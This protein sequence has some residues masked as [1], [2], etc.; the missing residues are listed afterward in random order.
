MWLI[1]A[2]PLSGR[3]PQK[4]YTKDGPVYNNDLWINNCPLSIYM[5][6][7]MCTLYIHIIL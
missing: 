1:A 4:L 5:Y 3:G 6:T 2:K 7:C